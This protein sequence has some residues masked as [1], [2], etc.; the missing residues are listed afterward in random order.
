[1][2]HNLLSRCVFGRVNAHKHHAECTKSKDIKTLDKKLE[3]IGDHPMVYTHAVLHQL[4]ECEECG[5]QEEYDFF[6]DKK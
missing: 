2:K 6:K 1:M 3:R 5:A 4:T